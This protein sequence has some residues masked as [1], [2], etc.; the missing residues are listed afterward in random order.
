MTQEMK[1]LIA[2]VKYSAI[3][4]K[5]KKKIIDIL[6]EK[7]CEEVE[8]NVVEEKERDSGSRSS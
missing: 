7:G 2:E 4:K 1:E 6:Y 5:S 3:P 8:E